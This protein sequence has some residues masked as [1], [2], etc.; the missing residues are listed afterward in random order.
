MKKIQKIEITLIKTEQE[1]REGKILQKVS[2]CFH[3]G[4]NLSLNKINSWIEYS[5]LIENLFDS[6]VEELKKY[7]LFDSSCLVSIFQDSFNSLINQ[8]KSELYGTSIYT[9][10]YNLKFNKYPVKI[11]YYSF[12]Q[13]ELLEHQTGWKEFPYSHHY[14]DKNIHDFQIFLNQKKNI[15]NNIQYWLIAMITDQKMYYKEIIEN[16]E[17]DIFYWYVNFDNLTMDYCQDEK[18]QLLVSSALNQSVKI[19]IFFLS[20]SYQEDFL[21]I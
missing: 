16:F 19:F 17:E 11:L 1:L 6:Y 21:I 20:E 4:F 18:F 13:R 12:D 9:K 2:G 8:S 3:R 14:I 5:K 7:H 10:N 15:K